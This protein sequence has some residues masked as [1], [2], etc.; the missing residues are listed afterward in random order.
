MPVKIPHIRCQ[1]SLRF[2]KN[3]LFY[4]TL[5]IWIEVI[6]FD[7]ALLLLAKHDVKITWAVRP[8]YDKKILWPSGLY[9]QALYVKMWPP[10]ELN[11]GFGIQSYTDNH[12]INFFF[13][14]KSCQIRS[15]VCLLGSCKQNTLTK[16]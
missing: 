1:V 14:L 8:V 6:C 5:D 3:L 13:H 10:S 9:S 11:L 16:S 4:R 15:Y 7:F 2:I 12:D